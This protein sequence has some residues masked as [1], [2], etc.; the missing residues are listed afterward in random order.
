MVGPSLG[1]TG[2]RDKMAT[3]NMDL[4]DLRPVASIADLQTT[5]RTVTDGTTPETTSEAGIQQC[6]DH[7]GLPPL[8]PLDEKANVSQTNTTAQLVKLILVTRRNL[9]TVTAT[10]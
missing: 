3:E 7:A 8:V 1:R 6:V 10:R 4:R 9:P 5:R 2:T